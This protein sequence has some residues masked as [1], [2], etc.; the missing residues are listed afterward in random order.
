MTFVLYYP[1]PVCTERGFLFFERCAGIIITMLDIK[2]IRENKELV[3]A[4]AKKKHIDF[5]LDELISVDDKR[6]VLTQQ[7]EALRAKQNEASDVISRDPSRR[8]SLMAELK[9]LKSNL[10]REEEEL[11]KI[12]EKWRA[13]MLQVPNIPD[14]SVPDGKDDSDNKEYSKW[15]ELPEFSFIPKNHIEL[16][17]KNGMLDLE[18]GAKVSGFRGYFLA[19]DAVLLSLS[20]W[21]LAVD[22]L[23]KKGFIPMITPSLVKKESL[24][25][26]AYLPQGEEDLYKTQD[27]EYLSGTAEVPTMGFHM[28]EMFEIKDLPKK[29]VSFSGCFRREAGSHGKDTQG[30]MRV[31]EFFKVE[32]VV[33]CEGTHEES[34]RWHEALRENAEELMRKLNIPYRVVIN[35]A[36]D[37]GLGQVKKY[38]I[39]TWVPSE[40]K[41]RETHSISYFH[42]FQA[43][44]FNIKYQDKDGKKRFTHSLNGTAIATPRAIISIIENNQRA[45]GSIKVPDILQDFVGK[46]VINGR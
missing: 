44:R 27:D 9:E 22:E 2:F 14:M 18:R 12:M 4:G 33:L 6:L 30:I 11:K 7:V 28:N 34:A 26:T 31:H 35:C 5:D 42:D 25:G 16:M 43:R 24:L 19:G 39:E 3:A 29:I 21:K 20:V 10:E 8:E 1:R 36:G 23:I 15:G 41:Y 38:D 45:D 46:K 32:Q 37:L 13:L 40:S 17:V